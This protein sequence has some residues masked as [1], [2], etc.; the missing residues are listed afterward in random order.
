M[1]A[2][3]NAE[4][5]KRLMTEEEAAAYTGVSLSYLRHA[6]MKKNQGCGTPGPAFVRIGVVGPPGKSRR[7]RVYY[8]ESDLDIWLESL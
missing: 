8:K 7:S 3:T 4:A 2:N 6:R 5:K 1:E